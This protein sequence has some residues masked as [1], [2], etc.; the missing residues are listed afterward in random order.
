MPATYQETV[1]EVGPAL[2]KLTGCYLP[3]IGEGALGVLTS[4]DACLLSE[5]LWKLSE[6]DLTPPSF[7]KLPEGAVVPREC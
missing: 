4:R 1:Q 2:V 6:H 3:P 7:L 5:Q